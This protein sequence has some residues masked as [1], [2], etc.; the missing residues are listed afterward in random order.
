MATRKLQLISPAVADLIIKQIAHELKNYA[1]YRSYANYFS[2]EGILDLEKYYLT[3]A[4]EEYNHH[5][6]LSHYLSEADVKFMYPAIEMNTEKITQYSDPFIQT[7]DREIMTTQMLYSI[8]KQAESEGDYMTCSWLYDKLIKEQIEEENTSRM[9]RTII[10]E[11]SD[12]Y[13]RAERILDL[14]EN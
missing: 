12:I 11:E 2:V 7:V 6:W 4:T 5:E 14:L 3:R 8:Y 10:E 9:A 13:L 1:L